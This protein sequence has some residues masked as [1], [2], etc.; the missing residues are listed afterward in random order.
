[1]NVQFIK[2]NIF[3]GNDITREK[4][5]DSNCDDFYETYEFDPQEKQRERE[6]NRAGQYTFKN[7][8][9]HFFEFLIIISL[10]FVKKF[11]TL[12]ISTTIIMSISSKT[13]PYNFFYA[14]K[15]FLQ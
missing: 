13:S 8:C 5:S 7:N 14:Q 10:H 2:K 9:C 4:A 6:R 3:T 12:L 11:F 15:Y 1:M